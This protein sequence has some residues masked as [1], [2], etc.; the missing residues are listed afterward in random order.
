MTNVKR[1]KVYAKNKPKVMANPDAQFDICIRNTDDWAKSA[2]HVFHEKLK[3]IDL[4]PHPNAGTWNKFCYI[5]ISIR[6]GNPD[7][8]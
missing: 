8:N 7:E 2:A 4:N 5:Q 1:E 3:Q 6:W